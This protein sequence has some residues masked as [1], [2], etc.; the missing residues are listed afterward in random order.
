MLE[1]NHAVRGAATLYYKVLPGAQTF[2]LSTEG[3]RRISRHNY[4]MRLPSKLSWVQIPSPGPN[5]DANLRREASR[6]RDE[7]LERHALPSPFLFL[8]KVGANA[9]R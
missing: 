5:Q 9:R 8:M 3:W 4:I 6:V 2:K 7:G 1:K